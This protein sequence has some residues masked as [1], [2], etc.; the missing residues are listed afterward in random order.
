MST[1]AYSAIACRLN[2][3]VEQINTSVNELNAVRERMD[4]RWER[5]DKLFD[6]MIA[7]IEDAQRRCSPSR[8]EALTGTPQGTD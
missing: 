4:K 7:H 8:A 6:E 3:S 5:I 2:A 1:I